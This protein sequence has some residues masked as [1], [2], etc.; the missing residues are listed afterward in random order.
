M[1]QSWPD[2]FSLWHKLGARAL[3]GPFYLPLFCLIL[4]I[5]VIVPLSF[6]TEPFFSFTE[7][8]LTLQPEA[9]SL[10]WYREILADPK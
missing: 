8:M 10:R 2:E 5:L 9:Y 3:A 6:N 7:G 1:F 4:P